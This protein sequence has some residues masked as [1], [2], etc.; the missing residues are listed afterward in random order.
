MNIAAVRAAAQ[1]PPIFGPR[2]DIL[3][4]IAASGPVR[5]VALQELFTEIRV[6]AARDGADG[7]ICLGWRPPGSDRR[8]QRGAALAL[9]PQHPLHKEIRAVLLALARDFPFRAE[10]DMTKAETALPDGKRRHDPDKVLFFPNRLK[11][12][13]ALDALGGTPTIADLA[14]GLTAMRL[15]VVNQVVQHLIRDGIAIKSGPHVSLVQAGWTNPLRR[16]VR[17]YMRLRPDL[18]VQI[19]G[20]LKKKR[21]TSERQN[22]NGFFGR[23]VVERA[24][25][26][27]ALH[28]PLRTAEL[29]SAATSQNGA[30]ALRKLMKMGIVAREER[31]EG[32]GRHYVLGLNAAH[33]LYRELRAMLCSMGGGS[34]SRKTQLKCPVERVVLR[35]LFT[36]ELYADVLIAIETAVHGEIDPTTIIRLHN[37]R[38]GW[39]VRM[40]VRRW[41][42]QGLLKRRHYGNVSLYWFNPEYPHYKP[43]RAL[44]S[45]IADLQPRR[46]TLAA[47]EEHTYVS[48]RQP[49]AHRR[50]AKEKATGRFLPD[51]H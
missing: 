5:M 2:T 29:E 35:G 9:D 33:P 18:P 37:E 39:N 50:R 51:L 45:R 49:R 10:R 15:S 20:N 1:P 12:L 4:V 38:D 25:I 13:C 46:R 30:L 6:A 7:G 3:T 40:N 42:R 24:L 16:L 11:V 21:A 26:A 34:P 44:L 48:N 47:V 36:S 28:G 41:A 8:G 17:A 23:E 19:R 43:L 31:G 27:L 32:K 22:A 14:G